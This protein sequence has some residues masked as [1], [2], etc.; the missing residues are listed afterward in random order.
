MDMSKE[1]K[2]P[3]IS[4]VSFIQHG[5]ICGSFDQKN[6]TEILLTEDEETI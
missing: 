3:V 1:Y 2:T 4:V 5:V 6:L